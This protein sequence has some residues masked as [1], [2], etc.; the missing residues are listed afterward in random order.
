MKLLPS[1]A[2][3][4]AFKRERKAYREYRSKELKSLAKYAGT[5][6]A[7]IGGDVLGE[8]GSFMMGSSPKKRRR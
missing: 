4:Q 2:Q 8:L 1:K 7:K 5:E 6:Y 3:I